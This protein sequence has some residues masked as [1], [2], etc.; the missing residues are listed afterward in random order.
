V[1]LLAKYLN[2]SIEFFTKLG[3]IFNPQF[4][5]ENATPSILLPYKS[6][7]FEQTFSKKFCLQLCCARFYATAS[8]ASMQKIHIAFSIDND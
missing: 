8:V 6:L 7:F 5:D 2:K 3:F 4:T 1:N